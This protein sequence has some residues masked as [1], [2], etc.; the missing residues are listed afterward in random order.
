MKECMDPSPDNSRL[1][2]FE[3][4]L[5]KR[6]VQPP[7]DLVR[8]IRARLEQGEDATDPVLDSLF[9][10]DP[11]LADPRMAQKTRRRLALAEGQATP[12]PDWFSWVAPLAAAATITFAMV[13]FQSRAPR[14]GPAA[15]HEPLIAAEEMT[16]EDTQLTQ[17]MALAAN[18]A[19][20]ADMTKLES[21]DRLAF[22][23]H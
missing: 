23:F 21:V 1:D 3:D 20:D 19:A 7:A 15:P 13:S 10:Q 17:I 11:Q 9:R 6:T 8:R 18:L 5:C 16:V 14:P 4:W 22:L 12:R 2:R